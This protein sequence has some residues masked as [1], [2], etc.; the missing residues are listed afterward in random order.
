LE[1]L[2]HHQL[3]EQATVIAFN[4]IYAMV[5]LV[6]CLT[7]LCGFVCRGGPARAGLLHAIDAASPAEVAR[8]WPP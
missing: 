4:I 5:P 7:A 3:A 2:A 1:R 6:I 8:R